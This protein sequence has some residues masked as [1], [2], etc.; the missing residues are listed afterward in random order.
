MFIIQGANKNIGTGIANTFF[1]STVGEIIN[2]MKPK[3][4][5]YFRFCIGYNPYIPGLDSNVKTE[6]YEIQL[7]YKCKV[8]IKMTFSQ[9]K[10]ENLLG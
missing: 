5:K 10:V 1:N 7:R 3:R 2:K 6:A 4:E 9:K 8:L